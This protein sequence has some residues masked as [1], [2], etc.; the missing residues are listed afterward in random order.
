[1]EI[2]YNPHNGKLLYAR[3]RIFI[4]W[5]HTNSFGPNNDHSGCTMFSVDALTGNDR[6]L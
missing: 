1:M 6:L 4:A 2:M 3:G 5:A